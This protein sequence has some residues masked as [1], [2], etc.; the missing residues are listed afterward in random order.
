M[1]CDSCRAVRQL[2]TIR[3]CAAASII[4]CLT[5]ALGAS[6]KELAVILREREPPPSPPL[7][8]VP[9]LPPLPGVFC[10]VVIAKEFGDVPRARNILDHTG[11]G[12]S[13]CDGWR[14]YSNVSD[15]PGL[16]DHPRCEATCIERAIR[17]SMDVPY[18]RPVS[19][20]WKPTAL[21]T[22]IFQKVWRHVLI[23][24]Q[25]QH[26]SWT[27]KTEVDVVFIGSH[28]LSYLMAT[29]FAHRAVVGIS[30]IPAHNIHGPIEALTSHAVTVLA[31]Q[32]DACAEVADQ[33][34]LSGEDEWLLLCTLSLQQR[35]VGV[36]TE[37][38]PQLLADEGSN[39]KYIGEKGHT[40]EACGPSGH[41]SYH[42]R[43]SVRDWNGCFNEL[44]RCNAY[45]K[46][47]GCGWVNKFGCGNDDGTY[48]YYC[49][50]LR[51]WE[52]VEHAHTK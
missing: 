20:T 49:C 13:S 41:V 19:A 35:G 42:P 24:R 40:F 43:R 37:L 45:L 4:W 27:V 22:P 5:A 32:L 52:Q 31:G 48:G 8:S 18:G 11:G 47:V 12:F 39:Q 1:M 7:P 30:F 50:C 6:G 46:S 2:I 28:L 10:F 33:H 25:Y 36:G 15:I 26:W 16:S 34:P 14:I 38:M 44:S 51:I 9:S 17:G 29:G 21:N 23:T 3:V